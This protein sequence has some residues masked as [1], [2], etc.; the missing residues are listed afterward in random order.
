M[1]E[2][3]AHL[4]SVDNLPIVDVLRDS[5]YYPAS[6][7]DDRA[8]HA[9]AGFSHSFVYVDPS[10]SYK[11]EDQKL[12]GYFLKFSRD[13][14]QEELCFKAYQ[15]I[16][17]TERDGSLSALKN[18]ADF[19]G[20]RGNNGKPFALWQIYE[21]KS[22]FNWGDPDRISVLRITGEGVA[23]YQ[24]LYF[25]NQIKPSLIFMF[26]CVW[27]NWTLFEERNSFFNRVVLANPAGHPDFLA[28]QDK[29]SGPIWDG[30]ERRVETKNFF[31]TWIADDLPL[32][33]L[34]IYKPGEANSKKEYFGKYFKRNS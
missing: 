33:P 25:S 16:I 13:I 1:P 24:A 21:K 14:K 19:G 2:W 30:Y 18:M 8:I 32:G 26:A 5:V 12:D 28:A 27:G 9:Y 11:L 10:I 7:Q 29:E 22:S 20:Y 4:K 3:L 23:T 6:W 31:P 17:P 15:P 34:Y